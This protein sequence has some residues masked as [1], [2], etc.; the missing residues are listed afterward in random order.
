MF[1]RYANGTTKHAL[2]FDRWC[3]R[4]REFGQPQTESWHRDVC[5]AAHDPNDEILGGWININ[6]EVSQSFYGLKGTQVRGQPGAGFEPIKDPIKIA[7][8]EQMLQVQGGPI[9]VPSGHMIVFAQGLIHR[10][11]GSFLSR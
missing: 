11:A 10:V 9:L 4:Q 8:Y 1:A 2:L 3:R 5:S 7:Q 6:L